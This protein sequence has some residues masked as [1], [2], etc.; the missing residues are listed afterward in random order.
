MFWSNG[1]GVGQSMN[2]GDMR[3]W[4]ER[5]FS[6]R[7]LLLHIC[8]QRAILFCQKRKQSAEVGLAISFPE[9]LWQSV[10][11]GDA[12]QAPLANVF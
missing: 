8:K 10:E 1:N 5:L 4:K 9:V 12:V 6:R 7:V 3:R 2:D 11:I